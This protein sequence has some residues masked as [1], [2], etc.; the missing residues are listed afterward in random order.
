MKVWLK[1]Q[2]NETSS[3][4][5]NKHHQLKEQPFQLEE[6][7]KYEV[8]VKGTVLDHEAN[9]VTTGINLYN[10][11][12]HVQV[13]KIDTRV[14]S[15]AITSTINPNHNNHK[16]TKPKLTRIKN[17]TG[18]NSFSCDILAV[19]E[20]VGSEGEDVD[21]VNRSA[22]LR[23]VETLQTLAQTTRSH[24]SSIQPIPAPILPVAHQKQRPLIGPLVVVVCLLLCA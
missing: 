6:F 12:N 17:F 10:P 1:H 7:L 14:S 20:F 5:A 21:R 11:K 16:N 19:R 23:S 2:V 13:I 15:R 18:R 4:A 24:W 22:D 8:P 9:K 3:N